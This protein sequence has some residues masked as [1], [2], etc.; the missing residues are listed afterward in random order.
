MPA[1]TTP[2]F[3]K[4]EVSHPALVRKMGVETTYLL[5]S[6]IYIISRNS[7]ESI[8]FSL[9]ETKSMPNHLGFDKCNLLNF[10]EILDNMR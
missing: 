4:N 8:K 3:P 1:A 7:T 2:K 10:F 6:K 5:T 9:K